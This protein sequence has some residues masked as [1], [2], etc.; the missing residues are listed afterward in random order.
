MT[1]TTTDNIRAVIHTPD[2]N[3][4]TI[5]I[6][7]DQMKMLETLADIA[8]QD[9]ADGDEEREEIA[10]FAEALYTKIGEEMK[11]HGIGS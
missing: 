5:S 3:L 10:E 1:T 9:E 4:V 8:R 6:T 7:F 2:F 11:R